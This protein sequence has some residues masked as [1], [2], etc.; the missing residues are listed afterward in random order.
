MKNLKKKGF[1]IVELVIVIAVIAVLAAVLIPTFVN[2]TKKANQSAD[3]QAT[4]QMNVVLASDKYATIK[5]AVAALDEAGYNALDSLTPVSTGYSFWWVEEYNSIVLLNEK[6]EVVFASNKDAQTNFEAAKAA[7]KAFNLKRGLDKVEVSTPDDAREALE[8]GQSVVLSE[9]TKLDLANV[10]IAA[11]EDVVLDLGGNTITTSYTASSGRSLYAVDNFGTITIKNGTISAR[12]VQNFG[13]MIVEEGVI[14]ES[15]DAN[16]GAAI[17]NQGGTLTING[18]T[19]KAPNGTEVTVGS[20]ALINHSGTVVINGGTFECNEFNYAIACW[21]G[22][23]TINNCTVKAERGALYSKTGA[24]VVINGGTFESEGKES[25]W[26]LFAAGGTIT[27]NGG[28]FSN[29]A[30]RMF[31]DASNGS[32]QAKGTIVDNR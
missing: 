3:I 18:G 17:W 4:R 29:T 15:I 28:T 27:V 16:G 22:T 1:T 30:G 13:T 24:T 20:S 25:G 23:T 8:K 26:S 10:R 7:G 2:L 12:G 6:A 5:E 31:C 21:S 32:D 19:F 9:N 11:G 14:I